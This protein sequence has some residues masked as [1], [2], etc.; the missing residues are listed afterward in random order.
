MVL[1]LAEERMPPLLYW[2]I[3]NAE[4]HLRFT[5]TFMSKYREMWA[6]IKHLLVH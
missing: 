3:G 4:G 5:Q 2:P 1:L 6:I